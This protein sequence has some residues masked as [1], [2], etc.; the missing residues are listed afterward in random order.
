[1]FTAAT[2]RFQSVPHSSG[3]L[4]AAYPNLLHTPS[5]SSRLLFLLATTTIS[6]SPSNREGRPATAAQVSPGVDQLFVPL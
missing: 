3:L 4:L 5:C 6:T 1:M 2:W